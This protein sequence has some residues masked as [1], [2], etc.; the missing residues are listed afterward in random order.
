[1]ENND[2]HNFN[3]T[4]INNTF[5]QSYI[6]VDS[7]IQRCRI[8]GYIDHYIC[9]QDINIFKRKKEVLNIRISKSTKN[10]IYLIGFISLL[11]AVI[12]FMIN[13]S[14]DKPKPI[15]NDTEIPEGINDSLE[16]V[17]AE[18]LGINTA[19]ELV[20]KIKNNRTN[21]L[22]L[23]LKGKLNSK[24]FERIIKALLIYTR[25]EKLHLVIRDSELSSTDFKTFSDFILMQEKLKI[26]YLDM[27][28]SKI[29]DLGNLLNSVMKLNLKTININLSN[30]SIKKI[31]PFERVQITNRLESASLNLSGNN[32]KDKFLEPFLEYLKQL[33]FLKYLSLNLHDNPIGNSFLITLFDLFKSNSNI[34]DLF[35]D[36]SRTYSGPDCFKFFKLP[37]MLTKLN[38]NLSQNYIKSVDVT[39]I[40]KTLRNLMHL[41]SLILNLNENNIDR[42]DKLLDSINTLKYLE[43]LRIELKKNIILSKKPMEDFKKKHLNSGDNFIIETD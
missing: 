34:K 42:I 23:D 11:T 6:H 20:S 41:K 8:C 19:N 15:N 7:S 26:I 21:E 3:V 2:L 28:G 5:K 37:K 22:S 30:N 16:N 14:K 32:L 24:L 27:R 39:W 33:K 1:M 17:L 40:S 10:Y 9:N 36:L 43:K 35:L 18:I 38:L 31:E 29:E 13:K 4:R 25:F 12:F